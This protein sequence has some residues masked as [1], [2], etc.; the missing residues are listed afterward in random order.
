M[1]KQWENGRRP[2]LFTALAK[3]RGLK[4]RTPSASRE[5][6]MD[7]DANE[8]KKNALKGIIS[9]NG[10]KGLKLLREVSDENDTPSTDNKKDSNH[11]SVGFED[12]E[13]GDDGNITP[14]DDNVGATFGDLA[15]DKK[16]DL[17]TTD[18]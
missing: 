14:L 7:F 8:D 16:N 15:N 11:L 1:V 4:N 3:L 12:E 13:D 18:L 17:S 9:P 10:L 5:N 6:S 2:S